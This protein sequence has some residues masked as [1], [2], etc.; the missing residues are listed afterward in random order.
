[1]KLLRILFFTVFIGS[2]NFSR[3][4]EFCWPW[5]G[6]CHGR[7]FERGKQVVSK[8]EQVVKEKADEIGRFLQRAPEDLIRVLQDL[9]GGTKTVI[10]GDIIVRLQRSVDAITQ[11]KKTMLDA[12]GE[13]PSTI[14]ILVRY[15]ASVEENVKAINRV[16]EE[17][18]D[19]PDTVSPKDLGEKVVFVG[20]RLQAIHKLSPLTNEVNTLI[21]SMRPMLID[22]FEVLILFAGNAG[23][24][25]M[26]ESYQKR[27]IDLG[28]FF[29]LMSSVLKKIGVEWDRLAGEMSTT[30]IGGGQLLQATSGLLSI[31]LSFMNVTTKD[32]LK[33]AL[34]GGDTTTL[35][36]NVAH[37][38]MVSPVNIIQDIGESVGAIWK[39]LHRL[40]GH[41]GL[42]VDYSL[43][44]VLPL[45]NQTL[46]LIDDRLAMLAKQNAGFSKL[47]SMGEIFAFTMPFLSEVSEDRGVLDRLL[48]IMND[49]SQ[50]IF[51]ILQGPAGDFGR[52]VKLIPPAVSVLKKEEIQKMVDALQK[53]RIQIFGVV[54][55]L[56]KELPR[57][58][59]LMKFLSD[60]QSLIEPAAK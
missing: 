37:A 53:V 40:G 52:S 60:A 38:R 21:I 57:I 28:I 19:L 22:L 43:D 12:Q 13:K 34:S 33:M 44:E 14:D 50:D 30:I 58:L 46:Q 15:I 4:V 32:L 26:K 27:L 36:A 31:G 35:R 8:I 20:E 51:S 3:A 45:A 23:R 11:L 2:M 24:S 48:Q 16:L 54:T 25:D 7:N 56:D 29:D 6:D 1:M 5:D 47:Y 18:K 9:F 49:L 17:I 10:Q 59:S 39:M 42:F 55:L 41:V